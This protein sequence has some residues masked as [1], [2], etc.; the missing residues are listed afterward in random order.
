MVFLQVAHDNS[1][2]NAFTNS[3]LLFCFHFHEDCF[4]H[5]L[6]KFLLSFCC[7]QY[8]I[9]K[10]QCNDSG[11][12]IHRI[13]NWICQKKYKMDIFMADSVLRR[14]WTIKCLVLL[15]YLILYL[16]SMCSA[17][18]ITLVFFFPPFRKVR[19]ALWSGY[20][21]RDKMNYQENNILRWSRDFS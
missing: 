7:C 15:M 10:N 6:H 2:S 3:L 21:K 16:V 1:L 19:C 13:C 5:R 12:V 17:C 18:T 11:T 14:F 8:C 9:S 20:E 4:L